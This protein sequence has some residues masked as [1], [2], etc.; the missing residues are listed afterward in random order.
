MYLCVWER[1]GLGKDMMKRVIFVGNL[2]ILYVGMWSETLSFQ[3]KEEGF[4]AGQ[5]NMGLRLTSWFDENNPKSRRWLKIHKGYWCN[6]T[7]H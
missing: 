1:E 5:T 4:G 7:Y 2:E 6:L 3:G